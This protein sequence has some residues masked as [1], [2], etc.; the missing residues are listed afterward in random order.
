MMFIM[1]YGVL[2]IGLILICGF[3]AGSETALTGLSRQDIQSILDQRPGLLK[4]LKFWQKNPSQML[5]FLLI[6]NNGGYIGAGVIAASLAL[7]LHQLFSWDKRLLLFVI[8]GLATLGTLFV[9]E[10]LPK[11]YGKQHSEFISRKVAG[12]LYAGT[13]LCAPVIR[14]LVNISDIFIRL[15]G[16]QKVYS[17]PFIT[18]SE[19]R[20]IFASEQETVTGQV[21]V[22]VPQDTK[23]MLENLIDFSQTRVE[24]IMVPRTQMFALDIKMGRDKIMREILDQRYSR[25]PIYDGNLDN[26]IGIVYSK[27]LIA[28]IKNKEL[29]ILQDLLRPVYYT[30]E[31]AKVSDVMREFKT[32]RHH[33]AIVVDQYGG[34][35]GLV[36]IEDIMEE[37]V[38]EIYDEYDEYES[39]IVSLSDGSFLIWAGEDIDRI[40]DELNLHLPEDQYETL[41]A[42]ALDIFGKIPRVGESKTYD[43][44]RLDIVEADKRRIYKIKISIVVSPRRVK[45]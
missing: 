14:L 37:I 30:P 33:M 10:I 12:I 38:G 4:S 29:I 39:T 42:L 26:I 43:R 41:A 31:M 27:D 17:T 28:S 15:L 36:T 2:L 23:R 22:D 7:K 45:K 13:R 8:P 20:R 16:G 21:R 32:G 3:F 40:N 24:E 11:V 1:V 5:T 34:T 9:G 25:V 35:A 44:Y 18:G 6:G 19:L